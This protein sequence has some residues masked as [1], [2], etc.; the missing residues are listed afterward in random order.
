MMAAGWRCNAV[1]ALKSWLCTDLPF[2]TTLLCD[3]Y[4]PQV[5]GR[6]LLPAAA[7][8]EAA[9][10]AA[11]QLVDGSKS[12]VAAGVGGT[13]ALAAASIPAP[14]ILPA[15]S[16]GS[17]SNAAVLPLARCTVS[18][19]GEAVP[20]VRLDCRSNGATSAVT[21]LAAQ[22]SSQARVAA[23]VDRSVQASPAVRQLLSTAPPSPARARTAC[24]S[25]Q[26][27][28]GHAARGWHCH[29][30]ALDATLHLGVFAAPHSS[31][32]GA[33]P[34]VPV[35]AA[36][37]AAASSGSGSGLQPVMLADSASSSTTVAS[38]ALLSS[39]S[40]AAFRLQQLE[41]RAV[42]RSREAAAAK[43]ELVNYSS[44]LAAHTPVALL[45]VA[46]PSSAAISLSGSE[47]RLS[48]LQQVSQPA[49]TSAVLGA[50]QKALCLLH[51]SASAGK[52]WLAAAAVASQ[53]PAAG[54]A[55]GSLAAV[56]LAAAAVQG[57]LKGAAAEAPAAAALPSCL[58]RSYLQPAGITAEA[59]S[60][61]DVF[62]AP[63]L[64]H[65]AW[66]LPQLGS[67]QQQQHAAVSHSGSM[68]RLGGSVFISGGLGS[69]GLLT[70]SWLAGKE[71]STV[72]LLGR[73]ASN[74]LPPALT[75]SG[76]L[77][78]AKQCDTAATAD[79]AA[80]CA[81]CSTTAYIHAGRYRPWL[82]L[83]APLVLV[84]ALTCMHMQSRPHV[85]F[86]PAGGVL[87]DAPLAR[88][89]A[90]SLRSVLAPKLSGCLAAASALSLQPLEHQVLFSSVA[91]L[92]GNAGQANYAAAN[93][94]LDTAAQ[95][96]QQ[97]GLH[98][99]SLQWGP[100][101]GGGMATPAVAASLAAK[102]VGLVQPHSGLQLLGSLL[103]SSRGAHAVAAPLVALEWGRMLRPAQQ[104]S[105]FFADLVPAAPAA[106]SAAEAARPSPPAAAATAAV[107]SVAAVLEEVLQLAGSATGSTMAPDEAFMSAGLDS[108]GE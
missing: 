94:A 68:P 32:S 46:S 80:A 73:S 64:A 82:L 22:L 83:R 72:C 45:S 25:M 13:A 15:G 38:Y 29:P 63:H 10:A 5:Q 49:V 59:P 35:A 9:R 31:S 100:W 62:A 101:S 14:L 6:V 87:R 85:S 95:L 24:G 89:T 37:F 70:A 40:E 53:L 2:D 4:A 19:G 58:S 108:L 69:L 54:G 98:A 8:L 61:G 52:L 102:G 7:M 65:G 75:A 41:S 39:S 1:H 36:Y 26:S 18:F 23:A 57:L 104:R 74:Q 51:N 105:W 90:A 78:V 17:S 77:V 76:C 50:S 56:C 106:A 67:D 47:G 11:Q 20:T 60:S 55:P 107:L 91:A 81:E 88:Q 86:I 93:A 27:A 33:G 79:V 71:H 43:P 66:L 21:N 97:A 92:L 96:W 48:L 84:L 44:C 30:A 99:C 16:G 34:K 3:S 42:G 103:S 28:P 12:S